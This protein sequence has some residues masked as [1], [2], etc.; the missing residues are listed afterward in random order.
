MSIP[1]QFGEFED[2]LSI[3]DL[4]ANVGP[5]L[6]APPD[7]DDPGGQSDKNVAMIATSRAGLPSTYTW[8]RNRP[9]STNPRSAYRDRAGVVVDTDLKR[10]LSEAEALAGFVEGE[11]GGASTDAL[12]LSIPGDPDAEVRSTGDPVD[13]AQHRQTTALLI[14][15]DHPPQVR[16][17]SLGPHVAEPRLLGDV[18]HGEGASERQPREGPGRCATVV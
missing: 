10:Q 17:P 7:L 11:F 2:A 4:L 13:V 12:A 6:G 8:S 14:G 1:Q 18:G 15:R 16:R 9:S 3:V 5:R